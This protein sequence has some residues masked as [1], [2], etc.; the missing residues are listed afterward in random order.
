MAHTGIADEGGLCLILST[1]PGHCPHPIEGCGSTSKMCASSNPLACETARFIGHNLVTDVLLISGKLASVSEEK[2]MVTG[3][4]GTELVT[5]NV[6]E[7]RQGQYSEYEARADHVHSH[8]MRHQPHVQRPPHARR[9]GRLVSLAAFQTEQ[10][11]D[12]IQGHREPRIFKQYRC[13]TSFPPVEVQ[14]PVK[15]GAS[16]EKIQNHNDPS[17]FGDGAPWFSTTVAQAEDQGQ[18]IRGDEGQDLCDSH[19]EICHREKQC[20]RMP[21]R[22]DDAVETEYEERPRQN[23]DDGGA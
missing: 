14:D 20:D 8:T 3:A 10:A 21:M 19:P 6:P 12:C 17:C 13:N 1:H 22:V 7:N 23:V 5:E 2:E 16:F 15:H 4:S 11:F 9:Q 18:E